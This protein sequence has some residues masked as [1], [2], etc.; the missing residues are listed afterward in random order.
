MCSLNY[1]NFILIGNE[2][3]LFDDPCRFDYCQPSCLYRSGRNSEG[4]QSVVVGGR[5]QSH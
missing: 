5:A 3:Y 2:H 1:L 4:G